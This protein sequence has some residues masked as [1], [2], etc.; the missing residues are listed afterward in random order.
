MHVSI[1]LN[2]A[3]KRS[4][5]IAATTQNMTYTLQNLVQHCTPAVHADT[6]A[7]IYFLQ[8][9]LPGQVKWSFVGD[10]HLNA[11]VAAAS[12]METCGKAII[13]W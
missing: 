13:N 9:R 8:V 7:V 5:Q 1:A 3:T 4:A 2:Q 12:Q 11:A 6:Q 10:G